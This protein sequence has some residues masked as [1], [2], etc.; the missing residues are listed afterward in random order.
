VRQFVQQKSCKEKDGRDYRSG[1]DHSFIP[2]RPDTV[3]VRCKRKGNQDGDNEP[4]I[5]EPDLDSTNTPEFDLGMQI[6]RPSSAG[7]GYWM[8]AQA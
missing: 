3:K 7:F 6:V 8:Q 5:V 2:A 4:A 1:P